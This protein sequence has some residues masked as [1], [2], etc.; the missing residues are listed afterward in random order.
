MDDLAMQIEMSRALADQRNASQNAAA[1]LM[2]RVRLLEKQLEAVT[3]ERDA[4]KPKE[5]PKEGDS[6]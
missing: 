6:A 5:E 4:L 2:A 3:A 1:Q